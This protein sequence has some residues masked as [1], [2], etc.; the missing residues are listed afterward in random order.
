LTDAA[1]P[2][3]SSQPSGSENH[4]KNASTVES[5]WGWIDLRGSG[6]VLKFFEGSA[7][8]EVDALGLAVQ[9]AGGW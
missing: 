8:P 2:I 5:G 9:A 3:E 1:P 6:P 4:P 7:L